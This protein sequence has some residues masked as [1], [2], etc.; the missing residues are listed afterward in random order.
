MSGSHIVVTITKTKT[1]MIFII[2]ISLVSG[3]QENRLLQRPWELQFLGKKSFHSSAPSDRRLCDVTRGPSRTLTVA[4][5]TSRWRRRRRPPASFSVNWIS[6]LPVEFTPTTQQSIA[7]DSSTVPI[8]LPV[9]P[10]LTKV[11]I[12]FP[13]HLWS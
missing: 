3:N 4:M 12:L 9:F 11:I 5:V 1:K 7:A 6:S 8:H 10:R 2:K 13:D